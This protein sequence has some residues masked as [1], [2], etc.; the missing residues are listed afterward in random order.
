MRMD[1]GGCNERQ[2]VLQVFNNI[3]LYTNRH[4]IKAILNLF[5]FLGMYLLSFKYTLSIIFDSFTNSNKTNT[6]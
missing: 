2:Y 4:Y 5:I 3:N 1:V 6:S